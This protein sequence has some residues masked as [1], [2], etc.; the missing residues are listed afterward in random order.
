[1]KTKT[2]WNNYLLEYKNN[3]KYISFKKQTVIMHIVNPF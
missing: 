1:M 2:V 3:L